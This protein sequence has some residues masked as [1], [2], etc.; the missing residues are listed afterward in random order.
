MK[1]PEPSSVTPSPCALTLL[2]DGQGER[3]QH[4]VSALRDLDPN[5]RLRFVDVS[6]PGFDPL[7]YRRALADLQ[8]QIH[9]LRPNGSMVLG[10][11]AMRL[12]SCQGSNAAC[13]LALKPDGVVASR[14]HSLSYDSMCA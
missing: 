10:D 8:S 13:S 7:P 2:Y 9:G 14:R 5:R 1:P 3:L 12:V 4:E 6:L 11:D